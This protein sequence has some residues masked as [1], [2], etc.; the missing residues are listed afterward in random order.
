VL[1][2]RPTTSADLPALSA[3]F[4]HGFGRPLH[5]EEW[6]WKYE[7][8]PGEA[9]SLVALDG[10]E[11]VAHVG[12]YA[13]PARWRGEDRLAWQLADFVGRRRGLRP[14]LVV[15]GRQLLADLPRDT[16]LPWIFG[17]PS[18]RHLELGERVFGYRWLPP[19]VPWEGALPEG[20]SG[21]AIEHRDA[22][23]SSDLAGDWAEAVWEACATPS[24]RRSAA[25][26]NWRYYARP[27]RYYR[28]YRLR[29]RGR[30]GLVVAAFV[31]G[32]AWLAEVWLPPGGDW[33]PTLLAVGADLRAAGLQRWRAWPPATD[34]VAAGT[35]GEAARRAADSTDADSDAALLRRLGMEPLDEV[36]PCGCRA[37]PGR[38]EEVVAQAR[39][40]YYAMGDHDMV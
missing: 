1:V 9:R 29:D 10:E 24:V 32:S 40:L 20:G 33:L 6:R 21:G 4:E 26:L 30:E 36:V 19:R 37:R 31:D 18:R 39:G 8:L 25:F 22:I 2:L 38:E 7:R 12:A 27:G 13:L 28:M 3:L 11:A 14:P 35:H 23:D 34:S 17:F 15:A 5:G 16:D